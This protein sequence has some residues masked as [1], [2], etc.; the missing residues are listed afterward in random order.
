[1]CHDTD[2]ECF[3]LYLPVRVFVVGDQLL[4]D[5]HASGDGIGLFVP[6]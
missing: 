5:A 3:R 2:R 1:M 6:C 4:A